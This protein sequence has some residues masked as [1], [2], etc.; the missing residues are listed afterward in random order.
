MRAIRLAAVA[1]L[2]SLVGIFGASAAQADGKA[3]LKTATTI[4]YGWAW[5]G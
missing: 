2:F 5:N 3:G 1:L 4:Q